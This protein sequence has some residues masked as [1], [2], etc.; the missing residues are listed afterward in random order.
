MVKK[1]SVTK[2]DKEEPVDS[3]LQMV[4]D[5]FK[6]SWDYASSS[7]HSRWEDNYKLYN[8]NRVK[9]GYKG[10]TNTFVPMVYSTVETMTAALFGSKPKFSYI[11]PKDRQDQKTDILNNLLDYYWDIDQWALKTINT[12]R[13]MFNLGTSVDYFMWDIDHP[14]MINVPIRD[15]FI[16]PLSNG[17]DGARYCGRRYLSTI[18]QLE[19]FE[20]V[21][22]ED[23]SEEPKMIKRF[24]NLDKINAGTTSDSE[25]TDKEEKDYL[26]GSTLQNPKGKQVEVIEYWTPTRTITVVNREI[27]AEDVENWFLQRAKSL[28]MKVTKGL[29]PFADARCIIDPSLFYAKGIT[30]F[31]ADQQELLN[32]ITNQNIDSITFILNQMYTIDPKYAD[33]IKEIE[34]IPGAVYPFEAGALQ[35]INQRP[36]PSDA[37]NE[38]MNIKNEIRETT[39]SNETI[40]GV[41]QTGSTTATEIQAQMAGSANRINMYITGIENG[42]FHRVAQIVFEMI[43]LY[44]TEPAMVRIIGKDGVRWELFDPEEFREGTY[45]P[46]VQ[47]ETS[48]ENDKLKKANVG[49]ELLGAFLNDPEIN[50]IALKKKVLQYSFE[51]DPDEVD[52]LVQKQPT[53]QAAVVPGASGEVPMDMGMIG[54]ATPQM[55]IM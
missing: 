54:G 9:I 35:P 23:K 14:V 6:A 20:I 42:Y 51:L 40:K 27:V 15:F 36:I 39:A 1:D 2:K 22:P 48:V 50:Q 17:L 31:I 46:R 32:D 12:G 52:E 16:D 18:E 55:P 19:E 53:Q 10:I 24:K 29:M 38:R 45:E 49:K 34:N 25:K 8:N 28:G 3:T 5:D 37:F 30:D 33:M 21:D 11:A 7:W 4:V 43:R 47:L 26:Y 13:G 41:G 44:V